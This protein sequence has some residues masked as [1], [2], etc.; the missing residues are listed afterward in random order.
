[1]APLFVDC[2]CCSCGGRCDDAGCTVA[3]CTVTTRQ[4]RQGGHGAVNI[5]LTMA[6]ERVMEAVMGAMNCA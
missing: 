4:G 1:M 2:S 5:T 6:V 3:L